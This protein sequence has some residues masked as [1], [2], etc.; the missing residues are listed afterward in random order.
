LADPDLDR[1]RAD[2][3]R[4]RPG[5]QPLHGDYYPGN[6]LV[7]RGQITSLLDWD[8]ALIGPAEL[9]L[10][11]AAWEW[12]DGLTTLDLAPAMHFIARYVAAGGPAGPIGEEDLR[13]LV[14][15]RLRS[16]VLAARAARLRGVAHDADDYEYE[17]RQLRA[18]QLL[19]P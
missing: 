5:R 19:R 14:R 1:W 3:G 4:R 9:E 10:A 16:E 8:E 18:F 7:D 13:Q 6:V 12:G 17:A 11:W 2:F 15:R